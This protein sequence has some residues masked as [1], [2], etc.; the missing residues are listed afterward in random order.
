M[1]WKGPLVTL[2]SD[3]GRSSGTRCGNRRWP[4]AIQRSSDPPRYSVS[5]GRCGCYRGTTDR[6]GDREGD[7]LSC[8]R[9]MVWDEIDLDLHLLRV[10]QT[11][12]NSDLSQPRVTDIEADNDDKGL[13]RDIMVFRTSAASEEDDHDNAVDLGHSSVLGKLWHYTRVRLIS[14]STSTLPRLESSL[15]SSVGS[16]A[17]L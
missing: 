7:E 12:Q 3:V 17:V 11:R 16:V 4:P 2:V 8:R 9:G 15:R 5:E 1:R 13:Q 14:H 6:L 10:L